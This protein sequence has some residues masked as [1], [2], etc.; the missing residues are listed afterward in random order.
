MVDYTYIAIRLEDI[1]VAF[2]Y[3]VF[4]IQLLRKKVRLNLQ[5]LLLFVLFWISV[6][7]SLYLGF[8]I[9]KTIAVLNVGFLN[10]LRRIEYMGIFFVFA[11]SVR[12][13]KDIVFYLRCILATI[14][15]V[16]VYGLGQKYLGWPAVQTMNPEYAKG[17]LL[18]LD[19]WARISST[20]G[21]HYDLAAYLIFFIPFLLA[22]TIRV[23]KRFYILVLLAL[24]NI[25]LSA[26]RV[27]YGAYVLSSFPFLL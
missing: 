13:R 18:V 12:T 17:Y 19:A 3:F 1:Y 6:F 15:I 7:I 4:V 20:F 22:I 24:S 5:Y 25:A 26:S 2:V 27:S 16:T 11:S 23:N 21:G 14:A 9:Q 8:F 10:S